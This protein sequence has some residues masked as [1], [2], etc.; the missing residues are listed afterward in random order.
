MFLVTKDTK[1]KGL[2]G[3]GMITALFGITE[4]TVYGVTLPLKEPFI[5]ACMGGA[6]GGAIVAANNVLSYAF[7]QSILTLPSLIDPAGN[8]SKMIIAV[9]A[10]ALAFGFAAIMTV[11]FGVK[12][13]K[14][15]Q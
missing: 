15:K 8:T 9:I 10:Y 12:E 1:L 5:F 4:P 13:S 14:K 6:I 11:L 3:S 2:A 7:G